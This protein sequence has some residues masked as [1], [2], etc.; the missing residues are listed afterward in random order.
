MTLKILDKNLSIALVEIEKNQIILDFTKSIKGPNELFMFYP[1]NQIYVFKLL[2][3]RVEKRLLHTSLFSSARS[4]LL[5]TTT[6]G[7]A[8]PLVSSICS[9]MTR[10]S[11]KVVE[12][13]TEYTRM[14]A[15]AEDI[16]SALI[17]GNSNEPEVSRMSRVRPTPCTQKSPCKQLFG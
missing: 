1:S 15:S 8:P 13:A 9:R 3:Y 2:C 16:D 14:K 5:P 12:S 4:T 6:M 7:T 10:T 17:A 11:S